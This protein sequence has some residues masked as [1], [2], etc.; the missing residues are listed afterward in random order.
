MI[1]LLSMGLFLAVAIATAIPAWA[2]FAALRPRL[3]LTG[4]LTRI[5]LAAASIAV[6]IL[7]L[8]PHQDTFTGLDT[9]CY[10]LMAQAFAKGRGLHDT[11]RTLL[12]IPLEHRRTVLLEYQ[13]WGR[14]TR[15]R[16][17]EITSLKHSTTKPY[18]YPT[19]PLA[20]AG[21]ESTT[22]FVSADYFVPLIGTLLCI[23]LLCTGAALA[24]SP[25]IL[26]TLALL[27]G[28]PLPAY[29]FRGFY[30]EVVGAALICLVLLGRSLSVRTPG[31]RLTAPLLLGLAV[32][33]HLVSLALAL[34]A[35]ALLLFDTSLSRKNILVGF[36]GFIVGL[37]P[38]LAMSIWVCQPYGDIISWAGIRHVLAVETVHRLLA[39]V[40]IVFATAI[41][42]ILLA[43]NSWKQRRT[44][45]FTAFLDTPWGFPLL[46]SA[47]LLPLAVSAE[48]WSGKPLI[49]AGISEY[50]D[51]VRCGYGIVLLAGLLAAVRRNAPPVAR[52]VL[53]LAVLLAPLFFYLKGFEQM[54]L[55]SQRRLI[56]FAMLLIVALTPLLTD[57]L[58]ALTRRRGAAVALLASVVLLAA[59][60]VN[61]MRWATPYRECH[62]KG[63]DRW[64]G[65][66]AT[67]L[68][69]RFSFFDYYPYAVPFSVSGQNRVAGLSEYG[70]DGLPGIAKWL[71]VKAASEPVLWVTA[72]AN[73][74]LEEG[75]ILKELSHE[76]ASFK[77]L[78]SKTSL[79]AETRPY[80]IDVRILEARPITPGQSASLHKILDDGPLALRGPWGCPSP[81]RTNGVTL[82]A[83]WSQQGSG[84]VGPMPAPGQSVKITI[85]GDA[86]RDDGISGQTIQV[87]APWGGP[88]L[89]LTLGQ[90]LTT[91]SGILLRPADAN[92]NASPT[93][94]YFLYTKT[95]YDPAKSG[96][97]G[98]P[99]DLGARIHSITI[100]MAGGD[101][102][103]QT[104]DHRP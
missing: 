85:T 71:A 84:V 98:Y 69:N 43:S 61:P 81:I 34:P 60:M 48:L 55:W 21:L 38:L 13:H 5:L 53:L 14:D 33:F 32:C 16:S 51:G 87:R 57:A 66:I 45:S 89:A 102:R 25:G 6:A 83:H 15:D 79:P 94:I 97:K 47:A 9:S 70:Y 18:F 27:F 1:T 91:T 74:G 41:G 73:P 100:E 56:P 30:A 28:T 77:R 76:T 44:S 49:R 95:P 11:D 88:K 104:L 50:W 90:N 62:E 65:S 10:R 80:G 67:Q 86:A 31:F 22:R 58:T 29:L 63:A 93:G 20:A 82:P 8:R 99:P 75:V 52:V 46:L 37:L 72:Y 96:I 24:G 17:F 68:A 40:V 54:G 78:V 12:E 64:V 101:P 103:P 36:A 2:L 42:A 39:G 92:T 7:L 23:L 19:L 59:G 4:P 26:A 3:A 35:L